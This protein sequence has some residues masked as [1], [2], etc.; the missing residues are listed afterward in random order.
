MQTHMQGHDAGQPQRA[1]HVASGESQTAV[2]GG[3]NTE[4]SVVPVGKAGESSSLVGWPPEESNSRAGCT[5]QIIAPDWSAEPVV[6]ESHLYVSARVSVFDFEEDLANGPV[7]ASVWVSVQFANES[8]VRSRSATIEQI[9][10]SPVIVIASAAISLKILPPGLGYTLHVS[11]VPLCSHG[12]CGHECTSAKEIPIPACPAHGNS[13]TCSSMQDA[14]RVREFYFWKVEQ[15]WRAGVGPHPGLRLK[16]WPPRLEHFFVTKV[17]LAR[18]SNITVT[19]AHCPIANMA[20]GYLDCD[21]PNKMNLEAGNYTITAK[22]LGIYWW[23]IY[24][25]THTI[26]VTMDF[27]KNEDIWPGTNLSIQGKHLQIRPHRSD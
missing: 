11:A 1:D 17:T 12:V 8:V 24:Q 19:E 27:V 9:E 20:V 10:L 21:I 15:V 16:Y 18:D 6:L 26:T 25:T 14:L 7:N 5:L 4:L 2:Q 13:R 22:L 23:R 3:D